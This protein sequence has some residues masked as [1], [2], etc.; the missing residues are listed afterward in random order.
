MP[1]DIPGVD[2]HDNLTSSPGNEG[3]DGNIFR[4]PSARGQLMTE[5][6]RGLPTRT[7]LTRFFRLTTASGLT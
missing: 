6:C 2:I 3:F 4:G 1:H 7:V 5:Q